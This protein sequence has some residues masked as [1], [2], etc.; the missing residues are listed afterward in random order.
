VAGADEFEITVDTLAGG[1][2]LV[3]VTG[4]LDMATS[5][6]LES[7]LQRTDPQQ[8]VVVD[9]TACDFLD[10]SAIRVLLGGAVRAESAGG[11]LSL[12]APD[13]QLRR[14][15]EIAGLEAKLPIHP[16]VEAAGA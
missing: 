11:S 1:G 9:L 6:E 2:S 10:S 8:R 4:E 16:T 12:V 15:L 14:V 13:P 5:A 7:A 3:G